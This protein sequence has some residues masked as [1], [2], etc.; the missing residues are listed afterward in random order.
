MYM[1]V[2]ETYRG[3]AHKANCEFQRVIESH[4]ELDV[5]FVSKKTMNISY[6]YCMG[7][8][9][10]F[11][12]ECDLPPIV[13]DTRGKMC[14]VIGLKL[15]HYLMGAI[16]PG[17]RL[18][19][20]KTEQCEISTYVIY[21]A[22]KTTHGL[23]ANSFR[24]SE[25]NDAHDF[26]YHRHTIILMEIVSWKTGYPEMVCGDSGLCP[27]HCHLDLVGGVSGRELY[28]GRQLPS[29]KCCRVAVA[30]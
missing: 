18:Y 27:G 16:L 12:R 6:S 26:W 5:V 1:P 3:S 24:I 21:K 9:I 14:G 29:L 11:N 28:T 19:F 10:R 15:H 2:R 23:C 4:Q 22:R 7:W 13:D 8:D 20:F 30:I 17:V 25:V